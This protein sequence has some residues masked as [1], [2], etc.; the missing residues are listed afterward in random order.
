MCVRAAF[1]HVSTCILIVY[2]GPEV[3]IAVIDWYCPEADPLRI[4][5]MGYTWDEGGVGQDSR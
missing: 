5:A 2:A 4:L 1:V 3:Y